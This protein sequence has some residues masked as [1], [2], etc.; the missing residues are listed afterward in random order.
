[1]KTAEHLEKWRRFE[2]AR[3]KLDARLDF[4]LW[5]WATLSGGTALVNAAL[6]AASITREN[7]LLATQIPHVYAVRGANGATM[8]QLA[9]DCDLIHVDVPPL[10][11][12][13][14][15][16]LERAFAAMRTL[17]TFRDPCVRSDEP[18]TAE[19]VERCDRAHADLL[20]ALGPRMRAYSA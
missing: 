12:S 20:A 5:F 11:R 8:Q 1:M 7:D 16:D 10:D 4:E 19:V 13:L 6:H 9:R 14:P 15:P 3:T 17:E 2:D 18:V